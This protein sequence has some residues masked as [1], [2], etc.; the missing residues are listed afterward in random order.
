MKTYLFLDLE[1]S[2]LDPEQD[3]IVE[4]GW[5]IADERIER[6]TSTEYTAIRPAG[7]AMVRIMGNDVVRKM[8]ESTGLLAELTGPN[9]NS[10]PTLAAV[11][12]Q[13]VL[14]LTR[15]DAIYRRFLNTLTAEQRLDP[16]FAEHME[17]RLAGKNVHFDKSFVDRYMPRLSKML[18]HRTFDES[19]VRSVFDALGLN[20]S[21]ISAINNAGLV[22]HRA[23]FDVEL[24]F[25][26]CQFAV[27]K[28]REAVNADSQ[29]DENDGLGEVIA[30]NG[31][32]GKY[33]SV[34]VGEE[35]SSYFRDIFEEGQ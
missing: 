26:T 14:D 35:M 23:G 9:A 4:V 32:T 15:I 7:A 10:L 31:S 17:F 19:T 27:N 13:I 20:M 2:G 5:T 16:Q 21:I 33:S 25:V 22:Q 12:A 11:E 24:S 18:S 28:L 6:I 29:F 3:R 30:I 1:T 34:D 8:H